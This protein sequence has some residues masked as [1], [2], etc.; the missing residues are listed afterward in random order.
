M[1]RKIFKISAWTL[2]AILLLLAGLIVAIRIPSVQTWAVKKAAAFL[3]EELGTRVELERIEIN[4]FRTVSIH[5]L[6]IEDLHHD[7]LLF[8]GELNS[9]I[10][11]FK[12]GENRIY[13]ADAELNNAIFKLQKYPD[14]K[15]LNINFILDYFSTGPG[16]TTKP[17]FDFNPGEIRLNNMTFVYRDNRYHDYFP[18][19]D[20]EDIRVQEM[21]ALIDDVVFEGD[22]VHA[23]IKHIEFREK[24]GFLVEYFEAASTFTPVQMRF[25]DLLIKTPE[26]QLQGNI[27]FDFEDFTDFDYFIEK[28]KINSE[29]TESI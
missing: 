9:A 1:I 7:T 27:T 5:N 20:F 13:L 4:F 11:I 15:G 23:D 17:A 22:T 28:V 18:G 14:E 6:Y 21:N 24:S 25:E 12:P 3:S 16:D 10:D 26:T 2:L 19:V 29:F 8:A